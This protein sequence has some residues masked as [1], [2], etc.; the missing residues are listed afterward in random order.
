MALPLSE[1][2][3]RVEA[4]RFSRY[5]VGRSV[6]D[7]LIDRYVAAMATAPADVGRDAAHSRFVARHPSMLGFVDG[8]VALLRRNSTLRWKLNVM[9]AIIEASP[10]HADAFLPDRR[11]WSSAPPVLIALVRAAIRS[12]VGVVLVAAIR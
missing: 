3:L 12:A 2:S 1:S 5:L 10:D 8:G 11:G 6:S 7:A 9:S 4:D